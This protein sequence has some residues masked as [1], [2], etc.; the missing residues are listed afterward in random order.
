MSKTLDQLPLATTPSPLDIFLVQQNGLDRQ[1]PFASVHPLDPSLLEALWITYATR[2]SATSILSSQ[3]VP[4]GQ[5][6]PTLIPWANVTGSPTST[7]W[8]TL[9]GTPTTLY[10]YNITDAIHG[11]AAPGGSQVITTNLT[12]TGDLTVSG[13]T[14]QVNTTEVNI[15]D[16]LIRINSNVI[17][18]PPDGL[19]GGIEVNRG[20]APAYQFIW[21][22]HTK[23]FRI[24][25]YGT[26]LEAVATREDAPVA[27][28]VPY[29]NATLN[30]YNSS[31]VTVSGSTLTGSLAGAASAVSFNDGLTTTSNV[32]FNTVYGSVWNDI[33]DFLEVDA[34][35]QIEFGKA[36][37]RLPDGS[38]AKSKEYMQK[39]VMGVASDTFGFGVG[40]KPKETPQLPLAIGGF[41][42]ACVDKIYD[43][44]TPL[45]CAFDG[46]LTE[47]LQI[48][49]R[50]FPERTVAI[51]DRVE[52]NPVW[53]GVN[54][55]GRHWVKVL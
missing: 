23:T 22:E 25:E 19:R 36:Y 53:N 21:D 55:K 1:L 24:G 43:P 41:V 35:M 49:K 33:A 52:K 17:G 16:N 20:S 34:T 46:S 6:N 9:T 28:T 54:V 27:N 31:E 15:A 40:H 13:T 4:M 3:I 44:G 2:I 45:T 5:L 37:V 50:E 26:D 18:T 11:S 8:G 30:E 38:L 10:G 39:G 47:F 7:A 14:I 42:L 29:W 51:F 12:I 32:Q 48:N